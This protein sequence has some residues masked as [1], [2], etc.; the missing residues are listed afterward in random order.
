[1]ISLYI[2][3]PFCASK[4]YYCDFFSVASS[5]SVDNFMNAI[6]AE[7]ASRGDLSEEVSTIYFGGGTPSTLDIEQLSR[8]LDALRLV[9]NCSAV[10]EITLEANP[11]QLTPAYLF[12]LRSIGFN[13]LSIGIQSFVDEHLIAMG[14]RHTANDAQTAVQAAR[15]AGFDNISVDLIYGLPF[16]STTQWEFNLQSA[17]ALG[18]QHI[19]AYHLTVEPLTVFARRGMVAV[20]ETVSEQH[21]TMLCWALAS[22]GFEHYEISNFA[23]PEFHSAHNSNY[24]NSTRYLGFGPSAHSYDGALIRR[25]NVSDL[26]RYCSLIDYFEDEILT[27][28]DLHNEYVMTRLRTLAGFSLSE[29]NELS[30]RS[31]QHIQGITI[32]GDRAF[33][34][35][36]QWLV[37]DAII[38][39]L[40]L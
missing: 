25:W 37:S 1:M 6:C 32:K 28:R 26:K 21:Y 24:W 11:E 39:S 31:L 2:H 3:I 23:L 27:D 5:S 17:V 13:R 8:I 20:D 38:S 34:A 22:A 33:I 35:P 36:E 19:S 9:F 12:A 4:C 29:Y 14:R 16:M 10:K 18:V 30:S 40:F 7:I 15:A